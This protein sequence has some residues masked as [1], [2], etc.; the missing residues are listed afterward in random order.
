MLKNL[1]I[2]NLNKNLFTLILS[3]SLISIFSGPLITAGFATISAYILFHR[4]ASNI[5]LLE[6]F[7]TPSFIVISI[8]VLYSLLGYFWSIDPS[9]NL[10]SLSKLCVIMLASYILKAK[11]PSGDFSYNSNK[12][13]SFFIL[14]NLVIL[15]EYLFEY[16]TYRFVLKLLSEPIQIREPMDKAIALITM[17]IP[18]CYVFHYKKSKLYFFLI[19][20]TVINYILYPMLAAQI[21]V[22]LM[23]SVIMLSVLLGRKFIA[24]FLSSIILYF[25]LAPLIFLYLL[26]L[27]FVLKSFHHLPLS[28]MYRVLMWQKTSEMILHKPFWGYGLNCSNATNNIA[29]FSNG[30]AIQLHPHNMF[31][32][33]WLESGAI[34][35]CMIAIFLGIIFKNIYSLNNKKLQIAYM[36]L[37][38]VILVF[39]NV[40]FGIWQSWFICSLAISCLM[41][42]LIDRSV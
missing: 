42:K 40:S 12:I 34:G 25:L 13:I 27:P 7:K 36:G 4:Q 28:W 9:K 21:A 20:I 24:F 30:A 10:S 23:I 29:K 3:I 31:L 16:P 8:F 19:I 5:S 1:F 2:H 11:L 41:Y 26:N 15:A 14:I 37:I 6:I 35:V 17:L 32:Q 18:A 39:A 22:L 38:S 33:V